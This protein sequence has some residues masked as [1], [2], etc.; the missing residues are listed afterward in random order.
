MEN[1]ELF[2]ASPSKA[3]VKKTRRIFLNECKFLQSATVVAQLPAPNRPEICFVGRS[4]V[5]KSSLINALA[6]QRKLARTSNMPGR[7]REVNIFAIGDSHYMIDLPGYGYAKMPKKL[8]ARAAGLIETYIC[9]RSSLRRVFILIDSRRGPM[10]IDEI[11]MNRLDSV[12]V[13]FQIVVTKLDKVKGK[14]LAAMQESVGQTLAS[15]PASFPDA[16]ATSVVS[17][18]GIDTLRHQIAQIQ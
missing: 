16:I 11:F 14:S 5:G 13:G 4:N 6:N 10:D 8:A 15:H 12:G 3:A 1:Q 2:V 9:Q 18:E 7:T 17:G